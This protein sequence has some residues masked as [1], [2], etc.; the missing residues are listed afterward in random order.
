MDTNIDIDINIDIDNFNFDVSTVKS[1]NA[2]YINF[3]K[4]YFYF[5]KVSF[6]IMCKRVFH[7]CVEDKWYYYYIC[8]AFF[9]LLKKT[10]THCIYLLPIINIWNNVL[11]YS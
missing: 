5:I 8:H 6:L 3:S 10:Q 9:C 4:N 2:C 11:K 1:V 7:G